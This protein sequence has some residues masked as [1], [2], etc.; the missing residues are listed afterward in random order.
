MG[1]VKFFLYLAEQRIH[2][3]FLQNWGGRL[4]NSN[5]ALCYSRIANFKF[6][7]YLDILNLIHFRTSFS[8]L[9]LSIHRL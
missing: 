9:R 2:D 7:L 8:R 6:Q 3:Q 4:E 1:D 5:R